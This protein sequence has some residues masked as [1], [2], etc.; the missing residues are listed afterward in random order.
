MSE[1]QSMMTAENKQLARRWFEEVWNQQKRES[2][3]KMF[4]ADGLA[5]GLAAEGGPLRGP[6]AFEAFHQ[7]FLNAFPDL[8]VA[9]EDLIAEDDKVA[10]RWNVT[11][12]LRGTGLG[13][14][15]TGQSMKVTG[16]SIL[17]VSKGAIVEA[18]NNFDVLGM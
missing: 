9:I 1:E 17:R 13:V 16:M 7:A 11:G 14:T 18:W 12:T 3:A 2:I 8:R 5:H 4:S 15:P 6:Q 10:I